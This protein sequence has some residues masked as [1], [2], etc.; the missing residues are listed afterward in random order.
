MLGLLSLIGL[1]CKE[2]A[3]MIL[4]ICVALDVIKNQ[5]LLHQLK[6]SKLLA[7]K[8][9][10]KNYVLCFFTLMLLYFRLYIIN[11][12]APDFKPMDN[13]LAAS[14][15]TLTRI[16]TQNY[17]YALNLWLLLCPDWLCFDWALGTIKLVE[18][19]C[20]YRVAF[21]VAFYTFITG[22]LFFGSKNELAALILLI[23]PFIP[24]SGMIK[25]GFVIAER[26]LYLPSIGFCL[27]ISIGIHKLIIKRP[28]M[29]KTIK[30]GFYS[31]IIIL[32]AKSFTRALEW[33]NEEVL[34][35]SAL[36]VCGNNA[37]VH[38]NI[39]RVSADK[40]NRDLAF[41][42]YEKAI[43]LYPE[44]ESALMNLGN[45]YR[46]DNNY[47]KAEYYLKRSIEAMEDF[48]TAWMNLGIVQA[49]M[50]N[51]ND[52]LSS[53]QKAL[54]YRK[55][56]ANC[57]YNIGNLYIDMS[58]STMALKYWK[59]TIRIEPKHSKAWSNIL[60]LLDN[61]GLVQEI[62]QTSAEA[63]KHVPDDA[64]VLFSRANAFGKL[65]NF[66]ESEALFLRAIQKNPKSGLFHANLG[67]LYHRFNK[68]KEA[69]EHYRKAIE[70]DP[71]LKSARQNMQKLMG[72]S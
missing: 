9:N 51:Y 12:E 65:G 47:E 44:Y 54:Q 7:M 6:R 28:R 66:N 36:N 70:L 24:A 2:S 20:D 38:Y 25:V 17:L 63:L 30:L 18:Q 29:E 4:P 14:N 69:L 59:E 68:K 67:V 33:R 11:F 46:E 1:L 71:N 22:L 10:V 57:Y 48:P 5:N 23:L 60:A 72:T 56:Y 15:Y 41:S 55:N 40:N 62:L 27:L 49:A 19:I 34:F 13:P 35:K 32:I 53:Y 8:R 42:H 61:K 3:I 39:A 50:K 52:A 58:N 16:L 43:E 45:L 21:V 26:V 37:K 31:L 64:S